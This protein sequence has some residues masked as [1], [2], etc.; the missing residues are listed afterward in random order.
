MV[1]SLLEECNIT[2]HEANQCRFWTRCTGVSW[3]CPFLGIMYNSGYSFLAEMWILVGKIVYTGREITLKMSYLRCFWF[4]FCQGY[5][6]NKRRHYSVGG[7]AL[8]LLYGHYS[9]REW[10]V[11]ILDK[12]ISC[13]RKTLNLGTV[14]SLRGPLGFMSNVHTRTEHSVKPTDT[15]QFGV[16]LASL[17][18]IHREVEC[19]M[20]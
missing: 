19:C 17:M 11:H 1:F 13:V 14:P 6:V 10:V 4:S 16:C 15:V 9:S 12:S 3:K 5:M 18:F 20:T 2:E 7:S 8:H